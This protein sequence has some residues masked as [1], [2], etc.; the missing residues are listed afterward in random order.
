[1]G[2]SFSMTFGKAGTFDYICALHAQMGMEG[3]VTVVERQ[4][5]HTALLDANAFEF[6]ED[7]AIDSDGNIFAGMAPT[8][9]IKKIT[10]SGDVSTFANL[11][12]PGAGFLVGI[13]FDASGD[14]YAAMAT[15]DAETH[16]IWK[17]SDDGATTELFASLPVE[18]FPNVLAFDANGD[19]F[20]TDT[21]GGGVWKIDSSGAVSTWVTDDLML[22][23]IPPGPLGFPIGANGLAF[24]AGENNL[25]VT[26]TDKSRIVRIPVGADGS[27]GTTEVFVEDTANLGG[28]DGLT[29]GPSGNLYVALFGSDAVVMVSSDGDISPIV[30]G[31]RVQNPSDVKFGTGDNSNTLYIANFAA[32]R[33]LGLVPGTPLPGLLMTQI[34]TP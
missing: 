18:G 23:A 31:G 17:I 13:D 12:A 15:F 11:P 20:V 10:P 28:P 2:A 26:V 3:S 24:D 7:L 22:G 5:P 30:A 6:P 4:A 16:G 33:L 29:F 14:L 21:I 19:M 27:A 34:A 9:E 8:G 32:A 25:Y 1:M